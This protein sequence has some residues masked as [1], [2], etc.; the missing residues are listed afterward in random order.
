MV[1]VALAGHKNSW[2]CHN[3]LTLARTLSLRVLCPLGLI[4]AHA[5]HATAL[6]TLLLALEGLSS[7][8][9]TP[10]VINMTCLECVQVW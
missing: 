5:R 6:S 3:Y 10:M 9:I 8:L 7:N 1:E 2:A 4:V